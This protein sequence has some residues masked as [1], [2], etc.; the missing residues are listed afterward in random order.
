[1]LP[2]FERLVVL[3]FVGVEEV[4]GKLVGAIFEGVPEVEGVL[5]LLGQGLLSAH[6]QFLSLLENALV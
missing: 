2:A 1:M 5:K 4:V 3:A 6:T